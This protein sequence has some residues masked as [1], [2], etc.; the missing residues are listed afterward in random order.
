MNVLFW[1]KNSERLLGAAEEVD[2]M[3][4]VLDIVIVNWNAGAQLQQCIDSI[5]GALADSFVL[6]RI[7]VVDNASHDGS[8]DCLENRDLPLAVIRNS[9]NRGFAA[10]CNQGARDSVAPY[11]LFLNPDTRLFGLSLAVPLEFM[12]K[13]ENRRYG[14]VGIRLEDENGRIHRSCARFP[15]P[16]MFLARAL[17]VDRIVPGHGLSYFMDAWDHMHS[18]PVNHVIGA[19]FMVRRSLFAALEGFDE[20][21]FVYLED[22]DFSVRAKM[23]GWECFYMAEAKAFHRGGGTSE[24]IRDRRLAYSIQSHI[25]Y[26]YKHFKPFK[27]VL[28]EWIMLFME[29]LLRVAAHLIGR[30]KNSL[31]ETF[32]AYRILYR[33]RAE[34][35]IHHRRTMIH[36]F[37]NAFRV[38]RAR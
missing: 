30:S 37:L 2:A 5:P 7:T 8:I 31:R 14:I 18:R 27:A 3:I 1:T 21:F 23:R 12:E 22:L 35:L 36:Y 15:T 16:R 17:G 19:F 4:A 38:R 25:R 29:P 28:L 13:R 20:R 26:G 9:R 34:T 10:A 6:N 24:N 33:T 11:I 32:D